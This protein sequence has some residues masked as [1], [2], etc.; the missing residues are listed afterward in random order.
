MAYVWDDSLKTDNELIDG[1]HKQLF[2]AI[3]SVL[4]V[5]DEKKQDELKKSLDFLND[6]TIK[7]FF[8]EERLQMQYKYPDYPKHRKLHEGFKVVVRDLCHQQIMKGIT[9]DLANEI[10]KQIGDWLV[11]HIKIEDCK[12]AAY[13]KS[14]KKL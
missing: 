6:Y 10:K 9:D 13:I 5:I 1:Q 2:A 11:T 12:L 7:H 4:Q 8:D 14:Q 3:N